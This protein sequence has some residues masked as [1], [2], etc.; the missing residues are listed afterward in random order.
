MERKCAADLRRIC[1]PAA[2]HR[3]RNPRRF[4][5]L[6]LS[7]RAVNKMSLEEGKWPTCQTKK[8]TQGKQSRWKKPRER[9][10]DKKTNRRINQGR[11]K[12]HNY[13]PSPN[14]KSTEKNSI[15]AKWKTT[16]C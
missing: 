9:E 11:K 10:P 13:R 3:Q 8:N 14:T 1:G 12:E 4:R 7:H 5:L 16:G 2:I 15:V 6:S